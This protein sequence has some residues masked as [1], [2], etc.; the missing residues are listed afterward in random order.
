MPLE[1]IKTGMRSLLRS[2]LLAGAVALAF[3]AGARDARACVAD[4]STSTVSRLSVALQG[5]TGGLPD[6]C[7]D[8]RCSEFT[9]TAR[10]FTGALVAGADVIIDLRG[11]PD[12]RFSCDQLDAVTGQNM[13]APGLVHGSTNT[14]GTFTF[15]LLGAG[16]GAP[17]GADTAPGT[18][19]GVACAAVIVDGVPVANLVVAAF[20]VDG[21][22]S[23]N[24]AV[25]A[26]DVAIVAA[27]AL[28]VLDGGTSRARDDYNASGAVNSAD[29]SISAGM[30]LEQA[31]GSGSRTTGPFC[32]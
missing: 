21:L 15:R 10:C 26:N 29:V 23:P 6:A 16:A 14:A 8:G 4:P 18:R 9:V 2:A 12:L 11:C 32:P 7:A 22:G 20:D 13:I 5:T 27:D 17:P 30:A 1:Q 3:A 19:A 28:R 24:A 25:N 31:Q